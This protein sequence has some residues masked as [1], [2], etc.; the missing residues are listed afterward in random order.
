MA[1]WIFQSQGFRG[2]V[3]VLLICWLWYSWHSLHIVPSHLCPPACLLL[4]YTCHPTSLC[5]DIV[6][7][8]KAPPVLRYNNDSGSVSWYIDVG[9]SL[10]PIVGIRHR[11]PSPVPSA[12]YGHGDKWSCLAICV[13]CHTLPKNTSIM[14]EKWN[15]FF[16]NLSNGS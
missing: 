5:D 2:P 8:S 9:G 15:I 14:K 13:S 4:I 10:S 3:H 6:I 12:V 16:A 11:L 1:T 7:L